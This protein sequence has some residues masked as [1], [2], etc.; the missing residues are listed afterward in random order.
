[1]LRAAA[2]SLLML[3]TVV[4]MLPLTN[5]SAHNNGASAASSHKKRFRRHSR[6]WWRRYRARQR[7]KRAA[8][9]QQKA[10]EA[11]RSQNPNAVA[12]LNEATTGGIYNHPRG[13]WSV[14][15]PEGW[16][17]RP[18][19]DGNE[20]KFRI[21]AG[22]RSAAQATLSVVAVASGSP[23]GATQR[24]QSQSLSGVPVSALRRTVIEKM[25][26]EGGWVVNDYQKE[27]NGRRVF[28]VQAQTPASADGRN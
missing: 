23:V 18:V 22:N 19:M 5:S 25:I 16:S 28:V 10:L 1:M 21:N 15:M 14:T 20:M 6:A 8:L 7:R 13:L 26:K 24:K 17:N 12:G 2:L 11:M 27:I 3:F 9:A 4:T